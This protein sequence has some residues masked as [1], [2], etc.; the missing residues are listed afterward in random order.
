[1][2]SKLWGILVTSFALVTPAAAQ[3]LPGPVRPT[4]P[5]AL[6]RYLELSRDQ[7]NSIQQLNTASMQFQM[8]K[9]R[10]SAQVQSEIAAETAKTTLD[11]MALGVRYLELEAIRRELAADNEKTY[12]EIQK[13]L[14]E[15]QKT[16]VR[17]L[18][19][20]LQLQGVICEAQSQ[21]ILPAAMPGNI[22]PVPIGVPAG[23]IGFASFLLGTPV[24]GGACA[25]RSGSFVGL[26]GDRPQAER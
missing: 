2:S 19:A 21:N 3:L 14:N 8:E 12:A 24:V 7:V 11:A 22:A 20:A 1:M 9:I 26:L 25:S 10:R 23:Q 16:K 6:Q 17:A 13:V 18:V 4:F 5:L 15:A